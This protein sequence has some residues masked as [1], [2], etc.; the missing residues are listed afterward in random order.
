MATMA[1]VDTTVPAVACHHTAPNPAPTHESALCHAH[2]N[3]NDQST[4]VARVPLVPALPLALAIAIASIILLN[5]ERA[6][7]VELPPPVSWHR[8]TSHPASLLLI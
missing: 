3:Q 5:V 4:D 7:Y 8:P 2:C 6:S 1:Q